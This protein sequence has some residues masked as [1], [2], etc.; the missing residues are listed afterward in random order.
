MNDPAVR[1]S[2]ETLFSNYGAL[3]DE[4][5]LEDWLLLFEENCLYEIIPREND[6]QNL[7]AALMRCENLNML[8][9]RVTALRTANEY[10]IHWSRRVIGRPRINQLDNGIYAVDC[11]YFVVQTNQDGQSRLF[12]AG[13]YQDKITISGDVAHFLQKRVIVDTFNIPTLLATPL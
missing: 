5:R 4:D 1:D 3:L 8:R 9:D 10:N 7:P 13:G 6:V 2:I 12:S 11:A